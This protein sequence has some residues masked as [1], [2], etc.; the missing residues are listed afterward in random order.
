MSDLERVI[1]LI[2]GE[3]PD[4][5]VREKSE[6]TLMKVI[7]VFLLIITFGQMRSFMTTFTTAIGETIYTPEKW[8]TLP[9]VSRIRILRHEIIHMRQ[10]RRY[11]FVLH[12]FLYLFFPFPVFLAYYRKKFEQEAYEETMRCIV[13]THGVA[14]L[15]NERFREATISHFTSAQYLWMWPFRKSLEAWYDEVVARLEEG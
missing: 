2:R 4:F 1:L 7:N 9:E 8:S 14:A 3:F 12:A 11:T 13:L 6:S 5:E 15:K 10:R